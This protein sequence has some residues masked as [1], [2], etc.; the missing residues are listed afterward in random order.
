MT[1]MLEEKTTTASR[2]PT[3]LLRTSEQLD[4][5]LLDGGLAVRP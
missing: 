1:G 5:V 3:T 2:T 4:E